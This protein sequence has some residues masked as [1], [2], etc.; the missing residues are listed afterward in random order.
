MNVTVLV[1]WVLPKFRPL[2]VTAVPT[3]PADGDNPEMLGH[4]TKL[5]PLLY[6]PLAYTRTLPVVAPV[7]TDATID[8]AVQLVIGAWV[9]LKVT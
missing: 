2:I 1:P 7:G 8:V 5:T 3:G 6:T 9:P 4:T